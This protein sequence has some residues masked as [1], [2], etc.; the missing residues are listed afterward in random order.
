MDQP[1]SP[2]YYAR[3]TI[4]EFETDDIFAELN[5]KFANVSLEQPDAEDI[6]R[7]IIFED[8]NTFL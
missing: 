3:M 8:V 2:Q 4:T 5:R 1:L 6:Y 7:E